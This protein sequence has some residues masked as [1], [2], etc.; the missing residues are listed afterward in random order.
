MQQRRR[1]SGPAL[2]LVTTTSSSQAKSHL[3][4]GRNSTTTWPAW[5]WGSPLYSTSKKRGLMWPWGSGGHQ[6]PG[7]AMGKLCS[8]IG[9][10]SDVCLG[11]E[12]QCQEG[13]KGFPRRFCRKQFGGPFPEPAMK[14]PLSVPVLPLSSTRG[15]KATHTFNTEPTHT[16]NTEPKSSKLLGSAKPLAHI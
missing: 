14:S 5:S 6:F 15:S 11:W 1:A 10:P 16:F 12:L 2:N 4:A 9:N 8:C 13:T 7:R 3:P